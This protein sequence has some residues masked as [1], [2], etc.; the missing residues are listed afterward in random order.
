MN[1]ILF[2][3]I[4]IKLYNFWL[5]EKIS[6]PSTDRGD[7]TLELGSFNICRNTNISKSFTMKI[8]KK[9]MLH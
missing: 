1:S 3:I 9:K 7:M 6:I 5:D 2:P 4:N 8:A